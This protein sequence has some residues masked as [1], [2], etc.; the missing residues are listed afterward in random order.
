ML[1]Q[2][3]A[4]ATAGYQVGDSVKLVLSASLGMKAVILAYGLPLLVL[5]VAILVFSALKL[6]QL[7]V[8]LFSLASV[9]VYYIIFAIFR[10]K[11]DKEFVFHI[12]Q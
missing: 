8:G 1:P 6:E 10:D 4:T 7:Y 5:L 2:T 3:L 11:L 12:E 9:A